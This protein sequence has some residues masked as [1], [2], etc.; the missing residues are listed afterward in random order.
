MTTRPSSCRRLTAGYALL[1][2]LVG[3]STTAWAVTYGPGGLPDL[4]AYRVGEADFSQMAQGLGTPRDL[5]TDGSNQISS[6][7]WWLPAQG[8][9]A[10]ANMD[11]PAPAQQMAQAAR[12]GFFSRL[13]S[14]AVGTVSGMVPGA[15]G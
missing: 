7:I 5:R 15:G 12:S 9:S 8:Y 13:K 3:F 1:A 2:A 11:A 6:A 10:P 14:Q 4:S